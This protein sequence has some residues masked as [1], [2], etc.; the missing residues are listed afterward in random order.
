MVDKDLASPIPPGPAERAGTAARYISVE[1]T[2][3]SPYLG[4]YLSY[5]IAALRRFPGG[6]ERVGFVSDVSPDKALA[7]RLAAWFT[8]E[9]LAPCHLLDV[10]E[11]SLP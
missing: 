8:Q 5:G 6:W 2:L 4:Q 9:Q 10:I 3:S 1:E 11:D 7:D